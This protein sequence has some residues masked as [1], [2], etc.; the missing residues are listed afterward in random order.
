MKIAK[1]LANKDNEEGK[2][3]MGNTYINKAIRMES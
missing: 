2:E 1:I 3:N